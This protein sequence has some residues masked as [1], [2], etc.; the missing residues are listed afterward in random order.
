MLKLSKTF[1]VKS[2]IVVGVQKGAEDE[3]SLESKN[4]VY[5]LTPTDIKPV[6]VEYESDSQRDWWYAEI[7]KNM[8]K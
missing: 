3:K 7:L 6:V 2:A 8:K 4:T 5:F 1:E